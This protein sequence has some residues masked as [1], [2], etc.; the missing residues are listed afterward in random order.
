MFITREI[1]YRVKHVQVTSFCHVLITKY[2]TNACFKV[3]KTVFID[4][5]EVVTDEAES[6]SAYAINYHM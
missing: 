3:E 1:G 6:T 4:F 5:V 2:K